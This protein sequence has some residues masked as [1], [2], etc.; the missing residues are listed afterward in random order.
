MCICKVQMRLQI[1]PTYY[2]QVLAKNRVDNWQPNREKDKIELTQSCG[3]HR[4]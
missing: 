4:H 3:T 1:G 2:G